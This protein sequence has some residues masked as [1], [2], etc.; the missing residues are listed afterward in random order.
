M[1]RQN[2][3][4]YNSNMRDASLEYFISKVRCEN[5]KKY[6]TNRVLTQM[7]WY[8]SE[9]SENKHK[10]YFWMTVSILL[11]VMIPVASVFA[12]GAI[13]VKV[14]IATLGAA[15]T[16]CN[17]Y[18]SLHNFKDLWFSYRKTREA[19]LRIL[20]CYFNGAGT[21]SQSG[22]QEEKDALLVKLCEEELSHETS[23][24]YSLSKK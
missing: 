19:L 21:F 22:T 10:Y 15:V 23:E 24:W 20:Y 6:I 8:S 2:N 14:L 18:I 17:S 7:K 5:T 13:W 4:E 3:A 1:D 12:D 11:G 9:S 16:A